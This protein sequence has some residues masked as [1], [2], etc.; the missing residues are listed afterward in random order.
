ME[1][2]RLRKEYMTIFINGKQQRVNHPPT[3]DGLI[4][5]EFIQRNA[6]PIGLH[7]NEIWG[8]MTDDEF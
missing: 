1:K 3:I 8:Y 2:R 5:D 7:Q 6:D 4:V